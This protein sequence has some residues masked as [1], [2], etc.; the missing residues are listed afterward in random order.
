[1][2]TAR[3]PGMAHRWINVISR[4][5]G[6]HYVVDESLSGQRVDRLDP[7]R[8]LPASYGC[9]RTIN[10]VRLEDHATGVAGRFHTEWKLGVRRR[11]FQASAGKYRDGCAAIRAEPR[12]TL[13]WS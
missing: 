1:M 4:G 3:G 5:R 12:G 7:L 9:T 11:Q 13:T 2:G 10:S 6:N 8:F